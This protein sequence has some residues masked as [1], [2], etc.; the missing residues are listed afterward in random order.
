MSQT[1]T[2]T[3]DQA[4]S[5]QLLLQQSQQDEEPE[6]WPGEY[7]FLLNIPLPDI[8]NGIVDK[9]RLN[10]AIKLMDLNWDDKQIGI[11]LMWHTKATREARAI[12]KYKK[13]NE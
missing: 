9:E 7:Y 8:P 1:I 11:Q 2:L 6:E 4:R 12:W 3:L 10:A 13:E 5:L